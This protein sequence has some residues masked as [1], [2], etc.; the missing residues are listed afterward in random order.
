MR[1]KSMRF[2][3]EQILCI[4]T[5]FVI[6]TYG[7]GSVLSSVLTPE[8]VRKERSYDRYSY[9]PYDR[10]DRPSRCGR[11]DDDDD[12]DDRSRE[13]GD[14][15]RSNRP[16]YNRNDNDD[17]KYDGDRR[18]SNKTST[19]DDDGRKRP[20]DGK[21]KDRH[22]GRRDKNRN[23][24]DD[25]DRYRP[26]YYDRFLRDPYRDRYD[27]DRFYD[28]PYPR[29]PSYD[30]YDDYGRYDPYSTSG[31]RRPYYE[32]Q[33]DRTGDIYG[34]YGPGIGRGPHESFRPWDETY[35]G[36]A[37]W[38]AGGRGY[39]FASGRPDSTWGQREY[40]R[41]QTGGYQNGYSSG[42]NGY[43]QQGQGYRGAGIGYGSGGGYGSA[44]GYGT[45]GGYGSASG[46]GSGLGYGSG[47]ADGYQ[48]FSYG[49][50]SGWRNVGERR[51]Y[52]DQ[53]GVA[54][55]ITRITQ[56]NQYGTNRQ[57][58][59]NQQTYK[60]ATHGQSTTLATSYLYQRNDG[61][62][63]SDTTVAPS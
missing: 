38:D 37:G 40:S 59:Q 21:D 11:C 35:R 46:Y 27:R 24:Y 48:D 22:H 54:S 20:H 13:R 16:S 30:R 60:P 34:G 44:G 61:E 55:T 36:Q 43:A 42:Y 10:D 12:D 62:V 9:R 5:V 23:R 39:Y 63:K 2:L 6:Q 18:D 47:Y 15:R 45:G 58:G 53:S 57:P 56:D 4:I 51:P 14:D 8:T 29:R 41:P 1:K 52:R 33:Y 25:R 32:D 49:Q 3:E 28:D 17:D 19:D 7:D 31:Y 50:T 26:D